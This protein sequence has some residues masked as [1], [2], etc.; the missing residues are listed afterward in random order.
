MIRAK[1]LK[2][3]KG[4]KYNLKE[5]QESIIKLLKLAAAITQPQ[6]K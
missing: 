1:V 6:S 5:V 4:R 2:T 3:G